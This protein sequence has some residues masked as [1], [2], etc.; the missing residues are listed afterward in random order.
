MPPD[1]IVIL[2]GFLLTPGGFEEMREALRSLGGAP[3][4]IVPTTVGDWATSVSATGWA[5]ILTK[6]EKT[7]QIVLTEAGAEKVV[8]KE[9]GRPGGRSRPS[10]LSQ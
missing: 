6:L 3:I 2:P 5:R 8:A 4:R 1:P 10:P 9:W 7:V